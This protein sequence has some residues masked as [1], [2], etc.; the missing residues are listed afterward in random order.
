MGLGGEGAH[1]QKQCFHTF[2]HRK[3]TMAPPVHSNT[4]ILVQT[5]PFRPQTCPKCTIADILKSYTGIDKIVYQHWQN[6]IPVLT[7]SYTGIDWEKANSF[8]WYIQFCQYLYTISSI[9]VYDF[10]I[11]AIRICIIY[12]YALPNLSI[13]GYD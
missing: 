11:S 9:L 5:L 10:R 1:G 3:Y 13:P 6:R 12:M 2:Y 8:P 4:Y 7:K